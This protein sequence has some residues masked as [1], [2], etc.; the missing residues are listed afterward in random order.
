MDQ[1]SVHCRTMPLEVA[2]KFLP[3]VWAGLW[4]KPAR[5]VFTLL[6]ITVAFILFGILAG[7]DA[8]FATLLERSRMDRLFT[9]PRFGAPLPMSYVEQIAKIPGVTV[10]APRWGLGGYFQEQTN[11]MAVIGTDERFFAARPEMSVT[12]EQMDMLRRT[13]TGAIVGVATAKKYGW[14]VGDRFPMQTGVPRQDGSRVWTFDVIAIMENE[15]QPGQ[16]PRTI[17]NYAYLDEE[18]VALK[19]LRGDFTKAKKASTAETV[20]E[21]VRN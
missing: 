13:R 11:N 9:D 15:D 21:A 12:K 6:S 3:L 20:L 1:R 14:K 17:V 19:A 4:R 16:E 7:I 10:V 2:M 8:G 18:R 5:T